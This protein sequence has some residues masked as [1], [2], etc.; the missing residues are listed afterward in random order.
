[1]GSAA[2]HPVT[3]PHTPMQRPHPELNPFSPP[4]RL[5]FSAPAATLAF[6][7]HD[8]PL[9]SQ[10]QVPNPPTQQYTGILCNPNP[11]VH[12]NMSTFLDRGAYYRAD[13]DSVIQVNTTGYGYLGSVEHFPSPLRGIFA[14]VTLTNCT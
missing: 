10:A 12:P 14:F 5:F 7:Q 9:P 8:W 13:E 3:S 6:V 4:D 2:P 11:N 1:M